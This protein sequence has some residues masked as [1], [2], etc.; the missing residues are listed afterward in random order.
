MPIRIDE[1]LTLI[2]S[3]T[4]GD[5]IADIGCDHGKLGYYL[6]GTERAK[7]IIATDISSPS[8]KKA[9][10]LAEEN[11][12]GDAMETRLGDGLSVLKDRE[13]DCVV[14]AG[15]GGDLISDILLGACDSAK[16]FDCY[17]LSPNTHPEKVRD[18]LGKINHKIVF[19]DMVFCSGKFYTVIKTLAGEADELSE[20]Q[21][22]FGK[23]FAD[24]ETFQAY[25]QKEIND[26][27]AAL[28]I[29]PNAQGLKQRLLL[30]EKTVGGR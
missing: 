24:S 15:M 9:K 25:A 12:V 29:N 11:G 26:A 14:I 30:L 7:R 5:C 23:F 22:L 18:A 20:T 17:V 10:E 28:G 21:R 8:L 3:L 6:L 1:R 13:T 2:A 27:K 19:D 4:E 16:A